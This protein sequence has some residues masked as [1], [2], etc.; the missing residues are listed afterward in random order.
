MIGLAELPSPA[1]ASLLHDTI[2][3]AGIGGTA[4]QVRTSLVWMSEQGLVTPAG[5]GWRLTNR[6]EDVA[7]GRASAPGVCRPSADTAAKVAAWL[8]GLG[9]EES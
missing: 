7:A 6:G 9:A 4:D 8:R 3:E 2:T 5:K 1:T